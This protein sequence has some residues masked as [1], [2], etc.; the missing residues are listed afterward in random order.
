MHPGQLVLLEGIGVT[1]LHYEIGRDVYKEEIRVFREVFDDEKAIIKQL[2]QAV[3]GVYMKPFCNQYSNSIYK[4]LSTVLISPF[5]T[6]GDIQDETLQE[7][8]TK[9]RERVFDIYAL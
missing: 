4:P 2:V 8:T 5:N 3:P 1:N 9:L 7:A 6:C